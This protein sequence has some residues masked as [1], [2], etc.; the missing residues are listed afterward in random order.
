L[1]AAVFVD[2]GVHSEAVQGARHG[3]IRHHR[4]PAADVIQRIGDGSVW[5]ETGRRQGWHTAI[6]AN[7]H[8]TI[9]QAVRQNDLKIGA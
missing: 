8:A 7:G 9:A 3:G 2:E 6:V 4:K 5:G 1:H